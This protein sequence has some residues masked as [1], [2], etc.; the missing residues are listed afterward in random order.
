MGVLMSPNGSEWGTRMYFNFRIENTL[1]ILS[2]HVSS[3][4]AA[5]MCHSL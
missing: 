1:D 5:E 2:L 4:I 3:A